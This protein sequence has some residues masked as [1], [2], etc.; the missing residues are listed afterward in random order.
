[1]REMGFFDSLTINIKTSKS[2]H[3]GEVRQLKNKEKI[4]K[5]FC[6]NIC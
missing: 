5:N 3:R 1:M 6:S 2:I 4:I